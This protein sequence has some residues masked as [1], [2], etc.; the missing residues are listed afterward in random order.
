MVELTNLLKSGLGKDYIIKADSVKVA[1][2]GCGG[3]GSNCAFNLV[4]SG[5]TR[6][7]LIDFDFVEQS[8]LNRQFFFYS[9][10][11]M[12]KPDAL[13]QNLMAINPELKLD[14][15][16]EKIRDGNI[17]D[18]FSDCQ[19]VVEALD[20]AREKAMIAEAL[21]GEGKFIVS[22][23][24]VAGFGNTDRIKV[25]R[26]KKNFILVGDLETGSDKMPVLSP[27]VNIAAAKQADIV[28]EY[29]MKQ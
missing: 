14:I 20:G 28:I 9:Q 15:V 13:A 6:L 11:G 23:S 21:L 17:K 25:H 16:K 7:K 1:I 4:R 26:I 10:I 27:A 3:L 29:I 5:I 2:A 24:G 18:M 19:V 8:N 22:A 12:P